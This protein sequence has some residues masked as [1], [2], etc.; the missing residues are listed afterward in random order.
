MEMSCVVLCWVE[1]GRL[2]SVGDIIGVCDKVR[3]M[4]FFTILFLSSFVE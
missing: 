4:V 1:G 2:G 3:R